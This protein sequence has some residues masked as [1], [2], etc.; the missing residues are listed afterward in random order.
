MGL[1]CRI[2][3]DFKIY[4]LPGERSMLLPT[5]LEGVCDLLRWV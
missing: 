4:P 2:R 1:R 3:P 5:K